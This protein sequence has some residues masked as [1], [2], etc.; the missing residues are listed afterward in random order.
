[1]RQQQVADHKFVS[2]RNQNAGLQDYV[3]MPL[4]KQVISDAELLNF[5]DS[6]GA[7]EQDFAMEPNQDQ[8]DETESEDCI[9]RDQ[10]H[11]APFYLNESKINK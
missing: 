7:V 4:R 10:N 3:E 9:S 6:N 5:S 1:M 11:K 8:F 2:L